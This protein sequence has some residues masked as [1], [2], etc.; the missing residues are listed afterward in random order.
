MSPS[1]GEALTA[2]AARLAARGI[3]SPRRDAR[4]LVALAARVEA[5]QVLAYPERV[6]AAAAAA[7]LDRLVARRMAGEPISRIAGRREFWSLPF[8]LAPET[9]DPRPDSETLVAAALEFVANRA[10]P[11]RI[12]DL[13][14]G[15]GCLLLA[16]LSELPNAFGVGLDLA[17][18]AVHAA[19]RNATINGLESR[20]SFLAGWWGKCLQPGFDLVVSNPP[21]LAAA[22]IPELAPEV[23]R[24]DPRPA[25]DGGADGLHAYRE[26]APELAR[27]GHLSVI[28]VGSGQADAAAA[29]FAGAEL[30]EV[31]RRCD[32]LGVQRCI[33]LARHKITVGKGILP[34]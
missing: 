10:A 33:V 16:L 34:V 22:A 24:F 18:G 21:Y 4:L 31:A 29:I 32:L 8:D 11:L 15:S 26:L 28:E 3:E 23:A 14:T 6:M 5:S 30:D 9:L 25:L 1:Y 12:L 27:L 20:A 7:Q 2:A 17:P 19:R 13:G